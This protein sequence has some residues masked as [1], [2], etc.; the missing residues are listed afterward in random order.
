M[1]SKLPL[2]DREQQ[3]VNS[4]RIILREA[5]TRHSH[6]AAL[7]IAQTRTKAAYWVSTHAL[8]ELLE[9]DEAH[10]SHTEIHT[11][12]RTRAKP[13]RKARLSEPRG[14]APGPEK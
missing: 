4:Y 6:A 3:I 10:E 5:S 13:G 12:A 2:T 8:N 9:R 11:H 7:E 14:N 1:Q